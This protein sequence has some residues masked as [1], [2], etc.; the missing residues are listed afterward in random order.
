[1][2]HIVGQQAQIKTG[3]ILADR[4]NSVVD[5]FLHRRWLRRLEWLT[6]QA[7]NANLLTLRRIRTRMRALRRRIDRILFIADARLTLPLIESNA[8]EKPL[9]SDWA[10]RPELW[11]GP[12]YPAGIA[13]AQTKTAIGNEIVLHHDCRISEL[14]LRQIRN[15]NEEDLAP[16]G[17]R[18]DVFKFD[19][20]FLALELQLPDSAVAGLKRRHLIQFSTVVDME[21]P[22]E[23]FA[24]LNIQHGPNAV[25][26]VRELPVD[27][28]ELSVDFDLAYTEL[29][30]KRVERAWIDIIFERPDMNQIVLRDITLSRRPRAEV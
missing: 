30:E 12:I 28:G 19:G 14:T 27:Q 1:M 21:Q 10:Y 15:T 22:L 18:M 4:T 5:R 7:E 24:R 29:N 2:P 16:F 26:L 9:H 6:L 25:Q 11:R 13:A 3:A 20:S 17:L 23:M 8:I